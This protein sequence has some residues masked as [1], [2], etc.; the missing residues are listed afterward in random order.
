MGQQSSLI[1]SLFKEPHHLHFFNFLIRKS[2][3]SNE[4]I[5]S[6]CEYKS[7]E[8]VSFYFSRHGLT[9]IYTDFT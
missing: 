2:S 3:Y 4:Y 9:P 8:S 7:V 6:R 5:R 1:L